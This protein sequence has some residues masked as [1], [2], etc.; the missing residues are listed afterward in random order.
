M[1]N[2]T[3]IAIASQKGGVGKTTTALT[4][5]HGLAIQGYRTLLVDLDPQGHIARMLNIEKA[6]GVRRWFYDNAPIPSCIINVRPNLDLLPGD[7]STD[8]VI[9]NIRDE[10]YGEQK[11]ANALRAATV[12]YRIVIMDMA[13]SLNKLQLAALVTAD[14]VIIPTRLRHT[15]MDG[16]QEVLLSIAEM[17][18][19]GHAIQ[20]YQI[21]PTF[22]DRTTTE[23]G[24]RLKELVA[25][26]GKRVW[27]PIMQDTRLSEA[28]GYGKTVW[29]YAPD[30]NGLLG[31]VNGGGKRLGG[32]ACIVQHVI[33]LIEGF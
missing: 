30:C 16:V 7:K 2:T 28:P 17:T 29:E 4:L 15:D 22:Y 8:K 25:Q 18:R 14:H 27:P 11:F 6:P 5:G 9:G 33:S 26:Y 32:Y 20:S 10:A 21:V 31:Y 24:I 1:R 13:P 19:H 3:F 12:N 23:T